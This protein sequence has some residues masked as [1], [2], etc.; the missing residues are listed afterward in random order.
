MG[1]F[2]ITGGATG[3]GAAVKKQLIEQGHTVCV[4]DLKDADICAD[5]SDAEQVSGV[6]AQLQQRFAGGIDGFIPC[7]GV[8]PN[9]QSLSLIARLNYTAVVTMTQALQPLLTKK[10]GSVVLIS[11][12]SAAFDGLNEQYIQHLLQSEYEQAYALIDT[13]DGHTAYAGSKQ[14]LVRW[15]RQNNQSFAAAGMRINAVAP[16]ITQTPLTDKVFA[17]DTLGQMMQDFA[18]SVPLGIIGQPDDIANVVMFL[19]SEQ[20]TFVSGSVFFVDGGHDAM[21]RPDQF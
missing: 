6:I 21:M 1:S 9:T 17:D 16:G 11:S 7:A 20:A 18:D 13:L 12:N 8:G 14:A 15:M 19:L 2:I 3:I 10:Q 5:L 4:V